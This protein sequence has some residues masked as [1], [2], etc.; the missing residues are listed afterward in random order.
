MQFQTD[1]A[2]P[3]PAGHLVTAQEA[4]EPMYES[5][6]LQAEAFLLSA[7]VQSGWTPEEAGVA[8]AKLKLKDALETLEAFGG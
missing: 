5:M 2:V 6:E 8:L 3:S 7:A 4:L 1:N